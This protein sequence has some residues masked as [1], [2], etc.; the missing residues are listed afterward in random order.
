MS[1]FSGGECG[2]LSSPF[3]SRD[4]SV[5]PHWGK[6]DEADRGTETAS[7]TTASVSP[8][9]RA[10]EKPA[11]S[12]WCPC[13]FP[14]ISH[15]TFQRTGWNYLWKLPAGFHT[16]NTRVKNHRVGIKGISKGQT[17]GVLELK[18]KSWEIKRK[19]FRNQTLTVHQNLPSRGVWGRF[20][21]K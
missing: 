10:S 16:L 13:C 20:N 9:S 5:L 19:D 1:L 2:N 14:I 4:S 7:Y 17:P 12:F 21:S 8:I 3:W 11:A 18:E 15:Y 6:R